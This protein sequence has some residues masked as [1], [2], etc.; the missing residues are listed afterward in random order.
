MASIIY[1]SIVLYGISYSYHSHI[2]IIF[3]SLIKKSDPENNQQTIN[4]LPVAWVFCQTQGHLKFKLLTRISRRA[5]TEK[6]VRLLQ[7][8]RSI[9]TRKTTT[10]HQFRLTKHAWDRNK[11]LYGILRFHILKLSWNIYVLVGFSPVTQNKYVHYIRTIW[12]QLIL[13]HNESVLNILRSE[14]WAKFNNTNGLNSWHHKII[15]FCKNYKHLQ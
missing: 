6:T 15:K 3:S 7:T 1:F 10:V 8:H 12:F 13:K 4:C 11:Q 9:I 2:W 5:N 14:Y